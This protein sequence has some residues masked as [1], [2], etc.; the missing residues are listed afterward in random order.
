MADAETNAMELTLA[1]HNVEP[2]IIYDSR[3]SKNVQFY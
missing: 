1:P 3:S 2:K